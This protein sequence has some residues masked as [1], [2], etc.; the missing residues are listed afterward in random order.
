VAVSVG[1]IVAYLELQDKMSAQLAVA[2]KN[3]DSFGGKVKHVG[4]QMKEWGHQAILASAAITAT[5]TAGLHMSARFEQDLGKIINLVGI[6]TDQVEEWRDAMLDLA[7]KVG[8]GADQLARAMF[9]VTSGGLRGTEAMEALEYAAKATAIGLG[10]TAEIARAVTQLMLAYGPS[11]MSAER[12]TELLIG[13]VRVGNMTTTELQGSI[14]KVIPLAASLG[15]SFDQVGAFIAAYTRVGGDAAQATTSLRGILGELLNTSKAGAEALA[16]VGMSAAG[17]RQEVRDKGLV[18]TLLKIIEAFKGNDEALAD[19][20]NNVRALTGLLATAGSQGKD[21]EQILR[22]VQDT[23]GAVDS[24]MKVVSHETA[25]TFETMKAKAESLAI[26]VGDALKP[27]FMELAHIIGPIKSSLLDA[28][29]AFETWPEPAK[30]ATYAVV[31]IGTV[32]APALIALGI[33]IKTTGVAV[34]GLGSILTATSTAMFTLGNSVPVLTARIWLMEASAK[35]AAIATR[36]LAVAVGLVGAA[37]AGVAIGALFVLQAKLVKEA[38]D[39][40]QEQIDRMR[41][42]ETPEGRRELAAASFID[43]QKREQARAVNEF[44]ANQAKVD[45]AL[46]GTEVQLDSLKVKIDVTKLAQKDMG[47]ITL[48]VANAF[49]KKGELAVDLSKKVEVQAKKTRELTDAEKELLVELSGKAAADAMRD[50]VNVLGMLPKATSLSIETQEDLYKKMREAL[51]I[52]AAHGS[53]YADLAAQMKKAAEARLFLMREEGGT[54]AIRGSEAAATILKFPQIK[55]PVETFNTYRDAMEGAVANS[56]KRIAELGAVISQVMESGKRNTGSFTTYFEEN[57]EEA[58]VRVSQM[59]SML[60]GPIGDFFRAI[61]SVA[62]KAAD[63]TKETWKDRLHDLASTVAGIFDNIGGTFGN[64]A[65]LATRALDTITTAGVSMGAKLTAAL[66]AAAG[67][68]AQV[69][70]TST[71]AGAAVTTGLGGA[72]AGAGIGFM[73]GHA[74]GAAIGAAIGGI[75]GIFGGLIG[76]AKKL[77]EENAKATAE[78]EKMKAALVSQYGSLEQIKEMSAVL[79]SNLAGLWGSQ[80]KGGLAEFNAELGKF[81]DKFE[82]LNGLVKDFGS[83]AAAQSMA[84]KVGVNLAALDDLDAAKEKMDALKEMIDRFGS[85][86]GVENIAAILGMDMADISE[87]EARLGAVN[88]RLGEVTAT[89]GLLT[90]AEREQVFALQEAGAALEGY[91]AFMDAQFSNIMEGALGLVDAFAAPWL[92][93][94]EDAGKFAETTDDLGSR[95]AD[96]TAK[97]V[98]MDKKG[99]PA[100][101]QQ[102]RNYEK[103]NEELAKLRTQLGE[104]VA[105]H[106]ANAAAMAEFA[107]KG[108]EEFNRYGRIVTAAFASAVAQSGDFLGALGQIGPGLDQLAALTDQFGFKADGTLQTLL[109]WRQFAKDNPQTVQALGS[110]NQMMTGLWNSG[111]LNAGMFRDLG[112]TAYDIFRRM[113]LSGRG[114]EQGLRAMQPTLQTLWQIWKDTGYV[115]DEDTRKLLEF[116]EA[117]GVVGEAAKDPARKQVEAL[118][119]IKDTLGD[120]TRFFREDFVRAI[121][122]AFAATRQQATDT[123]AAIKSKIETGGMNAARALNKSLEDVDWETFRDRGVEALEA[124]EDAAESAAWG[125]SPGGIREIST[126]LQIAMATAETA[127][128]DMA[129]SLGTFKSYTDMAALAVSKLG[130]ELDGLPVEPIDNAIRKIIELKREWSTLPVEPPTLPTPSLPNLAGVLSSMQWSRPRGAW[131]KDVEWMS[132]DEAVSQLGS[133]F[134]QFGQAVPDQAAFNAIAG[135]FGYLGESQFAKPEIQAFLQALQQAAVRAGYTPRM[136]TGGVVMGPTLA[137]V[138]ERGPE[139]V[140]PLGD[141]GFGAIERKLDALP[142]AIARAVGRSVRDNIL[143]AGV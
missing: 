123:A 8:V 120:L 109:G 112:A 64:V 105:E 83:V 38:L 36:G 1:N 100:T 125:H 122:D 98:D 10:D 77:R 79:G 25:F 102:R 93:M 42:Q 90:Q 49:A 108:Q 74:P 103:W 132:R 87:M 24:G 32:A 141:S 111:M 55:L 44:V 70:D 99:G 15:V 35:G 9:A 18:P 137:L 134:K 60:P 126:Q 119:T 76:H 69:M 56:K 27:A 68:A 41:K 2:A 118:E 82:F 13:T 50:L 46:G 67:I 143:L 40:L 21:F 129:G 89:M 131:G 6:N 136:G 138:G 48:E 12:A 128:V 34:S 20:V 72:A 81:K 115:V 30:R 101:E 106:G 142:A 110:L 86:E 107:A 16:S 59:M 113:E 73:F 80:G 3:I 51:P 19:F 52:L 127:G 65:S 71:K 11:V 7:P 124:I 17:L 4:D 39:R 5:A 28:A 139:A 92:T 31:G 45:R 91:A 75:A 47:K 84:A 97:I 53:K 63:D 135:R 62:K 66:S 29:K 43:P 22:D 33:L 140:V 130:T 23:V 104:V 88:T 26:A 133:V 58:F 37:A 14:G 57:F 85:I 114:G 116:A 95:I 54:P 96:L 121:T 117:H 61:R 94:I 78:V